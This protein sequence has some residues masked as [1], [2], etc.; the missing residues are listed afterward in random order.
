MKGYGV[1]LEYARTLIEQKSADE[2][3][4]PLIALI[5]CMVAIFIHFRPRCIPNMEEGS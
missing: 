3:W 5:Y 1:G 4:M 2:L